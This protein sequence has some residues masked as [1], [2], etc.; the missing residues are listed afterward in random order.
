MAPPTGS[1]C[2]GAAAVSGKIIAWRWCPAA[3]QGAPAILRALPAPVPLTLNHRKIA[4]ACR[5][6]PCARTI[7]RS[8]ALSRSIATGLTHASKVNRKRFMVVRERS[9]DA[10]IGPHLW[11]S[12]GCRLRKKPFYL[13]AVDAL[14]AA[15]ADALIAQWHRASGERHSRRLRRDGRRLARARRS[16]AC[17]RARRHAS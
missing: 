1:G 12:A 9:C 3:S 10:W 4:S 17:R 15:F 14:C 5:R 6:R 11:A 7:S 16:C 13:S 8:T 2:H